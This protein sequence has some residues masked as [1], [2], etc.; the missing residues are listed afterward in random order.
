MKSSGGVAT[1]TAAAAAITESGRGCRRWR[2]SGRR[3]GRGGD[4]NAIEISNL[5]VVLIFERETTVAI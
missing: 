1:A 5:F 4:L 2:D 3:R